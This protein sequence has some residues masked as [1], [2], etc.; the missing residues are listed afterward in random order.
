MKKIATIIFLF[1]FS[2]QAFATKTC[3][4]KVTR[5]LN[6]DTKC[7]SNSISRLAYKVYSTDNSSNPAVSINQW[8]CAESDLSEAL[9][10]GA[11][12]SGKSISVIVEDNGGETCGNLLRPYTNPRYISVIQ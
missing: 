11:F 7:I 3:S 4:G 9:L 5:L 2:S 12:Y 8:F 10:M 1:L 6:W